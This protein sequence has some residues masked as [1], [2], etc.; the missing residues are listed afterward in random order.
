MKY[1]SI[2]K[3]KYSFLQRYPG[4]ISSIVYNNLINIENITVYKCILYKIVL[5][6]QKYSIREIYYQYKYI[7]KEM[8]TLVYYIHK[9]KKELNISIEEMNIVQIPKGIV[10]GAY[11]IQYNHQY[12]IEYS[13]KSILYNTE[14]KY[15]TIS[16]IDCIDI[17]DRI[18]DNIDI[19]EGSNE[20]IDASTRKDLTDK[21]DMIDM[22]DKMDRTSVI[23]TYSIYSTVPYSVNISEV[24]TKMNIVLVVEKETGFNAI[25]RYLKEIEKRTRKRIM[26]VSGKGYPCSNTLK[27]LMKIRNIP[28]LGLFDCD[29]HGLNIYK[30][31]KYGSKRAPELKV[32][33]I[34]RIG[35]EIDDIYST[36]TLAT[37]TDPS[38][39]CSLLH[40][41]AR[42]ND[43]ALEEDIRKMVSRKYKASIEDTFIQNDIIRYITEK[44]IKYTNE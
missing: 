28:I 10:Y 42:L 18:D 14:Q 36:S 7:Y 24:I 32:P 38:L 26:L 27:F 31:Y 40:S 39:E 11:R 1:L 33:Q 30:V 22:I 9:V 19:Y 41:L 25:L 43:S 20:Y 2:L 34:I 23:D 6:E 8:S 4:Y 21:I 13:Y 15:N 29:P 5:G 17:I 44:I 16:R 37:I 12:R 3:N 35:I